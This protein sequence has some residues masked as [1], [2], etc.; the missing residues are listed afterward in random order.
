MYKNVIHQNGPHPKSVDLSELPCSWN[1]RLEWQ[2][3]SSTF[4][5]TLAVYFKLIVTARTAPLPRKIHDR[6]RTK[7]TNN[8]KPPIIRIHYLSLV[9]PPACVFSFIPIALLLCV[10]I[11]T[12]VDAI[13]WILHKRENV[14]FRFVFLLLRLCDLLSKCA[15]SVHFLI[16]LFVHLPL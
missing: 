2:P 3:W 9:Q 5:C 8:F 6:L 11:C 1:R 14:H 7:I 4:G 16:T 10:P 15:K 12:S 13:C